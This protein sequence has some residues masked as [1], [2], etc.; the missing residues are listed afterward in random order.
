MAAIFVSQLII[1]NTKVAVSIVQNTVYL[2]RVFLAV[3]LR[4]DMMHNEIFS[5][6][7]M[8]KITS[9]TDDYCT[10]VI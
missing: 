10:A 7:E 5:C 8:R 9:K 3:R 2:R 4:R 6:E 1:M